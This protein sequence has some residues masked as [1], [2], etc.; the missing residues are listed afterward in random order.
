MYLFSL[1]VLTGVLPWE[2]PLAPREPLPSIPRRVG[3]GFTLRPEVISSDEEDVVSP[4]IV[5]FYV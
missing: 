4:L 3:T 2:T 1:Q 5:M